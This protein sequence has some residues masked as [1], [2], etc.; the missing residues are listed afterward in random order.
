M[1]VVVYDLGSENL[2]IFENTREKELVR[3]VRVRCVQLLH[4]LGV[5]CTESVILVAPSNISKIDRVIA[6]VKEVYD[7]LNNR[8][9]SDG[10][11]VVLKPII[12]VLDLTQ[13]QGERLLPLA[14]RRLVSLIDRTI[15][16]ISNLID[17]ISSI[18]AETRRKKI[19]RNIMRLA[20]AWKSVYDMA[21]E[22]GIDISR[23]Y[24]A[25]VELIDQALA[26]C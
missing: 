13:V 26:W 1:K 24:N 12:Q 21:R 15:D 10:F 6:K 18:D 9:L 25:L 16:N 22:L 2:K 14:Q 8:L 20:N 7:Q 17:N 23:D 19:R 5:Q 11:N 4:S 3:C